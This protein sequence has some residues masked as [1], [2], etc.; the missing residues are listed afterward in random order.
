MSREINTEVCIIGAGPAGMIIGHILHQ[1]GV[2]CIVIDKYSRERIFARGRAGILDCKV[3]DILRHYNLDEGLKAH[4]Q[5]HG[6]CEFRTPSG[7][8][9]LDYSAHCDG[10]KHYVY[11]QNFLVDELIGVFM[12]R[13][14]TLMLETEALQINNPESGSPSVDCLVKAGG[15]EL[16]I[17]CKFIA[18]CDGYH[19]KA[20]VSIP[21][22]EVE[23][24]LR[25]YEYNWLAV[26][27]EAPPSTD[28]IIYALHPRGFAGHMLRTETISR[29]YLQCK[30]TDTLQDW[31]DDRIWSELHIR[32]TKEGWSLTE[33][34]IIDKS[35]LEMRSYVIEPMH[36]RNLYLAGDAA[37]TITPCG[38]KGLN[39]AI[40]DGEELARAFIRHLRH[41]DKE[42]MAG[43]S[44]S[45]LPQ[46]WQHEEFS[47]TMLE[48]IHKTSSE[49]DDD[50]FLMK[51]KESRIAQLANY[52]STARDFSRKY[53]G[54]RLPPRAKL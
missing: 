42:A 47:H 33:G 25:N 17:N 29:Y 53:V 37:H 18:G 35:I 26:L 1:H 2:D 10:D 41:G 14:G 4:G 49:G 48:T 52:P 20:R 39:L 30:D 28:K 6:S 51:L 22:D 21:E 50:P 5:P 19:G 46:I 44:K 16:R 8:Q 32:F 24:Y 23:V 3:A 54:E 40:H 45:R 15:E 12:E 13:G 36:Y 11:A 43:Y 34:K 31:P 9:V 38:G 27:A 7:S